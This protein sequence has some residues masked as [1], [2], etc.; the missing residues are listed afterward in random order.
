[1][2]TLEFAVVN[3]KAAKRDPHPY[4]YVEDDGSFRE[5]C[6]DEKE[7]LEEKFHPGDGARPYVKFFYRTKTP[8][9]RLSGFCR[10][11]KIP[12]GLAA[13]EKPKPRKRW[14]FWK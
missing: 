6:D 9:G 2:G 12:K 8:D 5:L 1:M 4:V 14:Q 11:R 13:G 10:R 7:Y 3:E